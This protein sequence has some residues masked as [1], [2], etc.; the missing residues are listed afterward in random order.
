MKKT[1]LINEHE[2]LIDDEKLRTGGYAS[3]YVKYMNSQILINV[4]KH[5]EDD[6]NQMILDVRE[7]FYSQNSI[8]GG[9]FKKEGGPRE[10]EILLSRLID[11]N[12]R[13]I[14]SLLGNYSIGVD[15][16][17]LHRDTVIEYTILQ[18]ILFAFYFLKFTSSCP[19]AYVDSDTGIYIS[20][21][22][23]NI[24]SLNQHGL[25]SIDNL[26]KHIEKAF[27]TESEISNQLSNESL[28]NE[29]ITDDF[30]AET[31]MKILN[32]HSNDRKCDEHIESVKIHFKRYLD[33]KT[34]Y[35]SCIYA[36]G[37][38]FE[39]KNTRIDGRKEITDI[40]NISIYPDIIDFKHY[41]TLFCRGDTK[42]LSI[43]TI[44]DEKS[45][46][47]INNPKENAE[48]KFMVHFFNNSRI[49]S[50][51]L[52]QRPGIR[53][54]I[55]HANIVRSALIDNINIDS[56]FNSLRM[57]CEVISS[58]GSSSMASVCASSINLFNTNLSEKI[59]TGV[60]IGMLKGN[61]EHLCVDI[62]RLEDFYGLMD[63]KLTFDGQNV[64][65]I[66]SDCKHIGAIRKNNIY[67]IID[68][69]IKG[70]QKIQHF[71]FSNIGNYKKDI[72][73]LLHV[74]HEYMLDHIHEDN[75][76][77]FKGSLIGKG[78]ENIKQMSLD[79]NINID[80]KDDRVLLTG[81]L[82]D[83]ERCIDNINILAEKIQLKN[84]LNKNFNKKNYRKN[85]KNSND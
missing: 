2:F 12:V 4:A 8:S 32:H 6:V 17:I 44:G 80:L 22:K 27:K 60:T 13:P 67:E 54:E 47:I 79:F 34:I 31:C 38:R 23:D 53:R 66:Q 70:N 43:L 9:F 37:R 29:F 28:N 65:N 84:R 49:T 11:R 5:E 68:M 59:V 1:I 74:K 82:K 48:D 16:L 50:N 41:S 21:I 51:I 15:V 73:H 36:M 77:Y 10:D 25:I 75:L 26:K 30:V 64:T 69:A 62:S 63:F 40:R 72:N 57:A 20:L 45:S 71:I 35:N 14:F 7:R 85:R 83:I 39:L 19:V 76:N 55:G 33:E 46:Q 18:G 3:F 78:G 56:L 81:M 61:E 58:D 24:I 42:V 52:N